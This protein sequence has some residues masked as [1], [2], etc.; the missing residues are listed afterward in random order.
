[1]RTAP[2][3]IGVFMIF[4]MT[5]LNSDLLLCRLER[6]LSLWK[7]CRGNAVTEMALSAACGVENTEDRRDREVR[8][9]PVPCLFL[10]FGLFNI[11]IWP[12]G[13]VTGRM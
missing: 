9:G 13:L 7:S 10:S 6:Q 3:F 11:W 2:D 1:M 8:Q 5:N 4:R 12:F